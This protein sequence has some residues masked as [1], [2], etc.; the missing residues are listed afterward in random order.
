[1]E[2]HLF[3]CCPPSVLMSIDVLVVT[4]VKRAEPSLLPASLLWQGINPRP[5]LPARLP[6]PT[7]YIHVQQAYSIS[8]A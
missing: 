8:V 6:P 7:V 4:R 1:M 2:F 5:P 3:C